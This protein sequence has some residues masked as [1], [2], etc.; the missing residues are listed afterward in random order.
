[1]LSLFGV[2]M[3]FNEIAPDKATAD[4]DDVFFIVVACFHTVMSSHF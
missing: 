4:N 1:M 2:I 3:M